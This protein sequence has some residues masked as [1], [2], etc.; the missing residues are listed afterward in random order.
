M[1][2]ITF[3]I[4]NMKKI[5]KKNLLEFIFLFTILF[6]GAIYLWYTLP[7]LNDIL[8]IVLVTISIVL[9]IILSIFLKSYLNQK[10]SK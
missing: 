6:L 7:K 8:R 3:W 1:T 5:T 4:E 9:I 2:T 10:T